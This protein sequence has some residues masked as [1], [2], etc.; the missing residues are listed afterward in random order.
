MHRSI[1]EFNRICVKAARE[2][3]YAQHVEALKKIK[4][5]VNN[6]HPLDGIPVS[7]NKKKKNPEK[8]Q[9]EEGKVI[10]DKMGVKKRE[11]KQE[12]LAQRPYTL[13]GQAQ[14]DEMLRINY[15]NSKI[16]KAVQHKKPT[17]SRNDWLEHRIEHDY[18]VT[19]ISEFK[20]TVPKSNIIRSEFDQTKK[21][22]TS[23][24]LSPS[25]NSTMKSNKSDENTVPPPSHQ[26]LVEDQNESSINNKPEEKP[27]NN[28]PEEKPINNEPEENSSEKKT[29][30]SHNNEKINELFE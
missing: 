28:E 17:L 5:S 3:A 13:R 7:L 2:R 12:K 27:I 30:T 4:P 11:I 29:L 24:S 6:K 8:P 9:G 25:H 1:P 15:E 18:Q 10:S 14:K 26:I 16:L 19:K 20:K 21:S 23:L 22:S